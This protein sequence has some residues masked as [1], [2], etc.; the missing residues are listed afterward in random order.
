MARKINVGWHDRTTRIVVGIAIVAA[1]F[2]WASNWYWLALLGLYPI[3]TA[4]GG[5][6]PVYEVLD[7]TTDTTVNR[8][9]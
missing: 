5:W 8:K 2:I 3:L 4:A 6:C 9:G 1:V 7:H